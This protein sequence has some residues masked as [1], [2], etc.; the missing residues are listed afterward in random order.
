MG[1]RRVLEDILQCGTY[2]DQPKPLTGDLAFRWMPQH[3]EHPQCQRHSFNSWW[4]LYRLDWMHAL[5]RVQGDTDPHWGATSLASFFVV[6]Q[7]VLVSLW[8]VV[9]VL[10]DG[11]CQ[12]ASTWMPGNMFS[13]HYNM[14]ISVIHLACLWF[15]CFGWLVYIYNISVVDLT[16]SRHSGLMLM[17]SFITDPFVL[18]KVT[19]LHSNSYPWW[20]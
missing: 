7:N 10:V 5:S 16:L 1:D 8:A 17:L 18:I 9:C 13:L 15:Y 14:M 2:M 19:L 4:G 12:A 11:A 3:A 20:T 6:Y